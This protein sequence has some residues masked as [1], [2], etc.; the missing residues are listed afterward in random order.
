MFIPIILII[1]LWVVSNGFFISFFNGS[2]DASR[3]NVELSLAEQFKNNFILSTFARGLI[4]PFVTF[5][6]AG[7]H[8][9][10][11]MPY[12]MYIPFILSIT[13]ALFHFKDE[14]NNNKGLKI[15]LISFALVG[16][17]YL[18]LVW[19]GIMTLLLTRIVDSTGWYF[20]IFAPWL[21]PILGISISSILKT[22]IRT[23]IFF[24]FKY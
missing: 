2:W 23:N 15:L 22:R 3:L 19:H 10:V 24:T 4:V 5:I 17:I 12:W 6:W 20:H 13:W 1:G 14:L 16:S 8:S 7:S 21:A 18:G 11:H 9:L